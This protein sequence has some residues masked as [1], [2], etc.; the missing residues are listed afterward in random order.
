[1]SAQNAILEAIEDVIA[2]CNEAQTMATVRR[3]ALATGAGIT[4][5]IGP[6]VPD[7]HFMNKDLVVP[8][9]LTFNGKSDNLKTILQAMDDIHYNLTRRTVYPAGVGWEIV[10]IVDATLPQVIGREPNNDWLLASS[11]TVRLHIM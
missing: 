9:D 1:M 2:M 4:C 7:T 5:E 10:D 3:G 6:S 11:V 8:V